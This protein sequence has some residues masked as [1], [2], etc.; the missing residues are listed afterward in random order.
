VVSS[1]QP[2]SKFW[3]IPKVLKTAKIDISVTVSSDISAD[4]KISE[5]FWFTRGEASDHFQT[6]PC[7]MMIQNKMP[8]I[9]QANVSIA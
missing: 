5:N 1:E 4:T 6:A 7:L 2:K 9:I 3:P 8:A